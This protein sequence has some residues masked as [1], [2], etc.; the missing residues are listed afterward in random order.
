MYISLFIFFL[1][2]FL[3]VAKDWNVQPGSLKKQF[4]NHC[5]G[6][7]DLHTDHS[8][9]GYGVWIPLPQDTGN[10]RVTTVYLPHASKLSIPKGGMNNWVSLS[11]SLSVLDS[12]LSS[13]LVLVC[14][15]REVGTV[16]E[17]QSVFCIS[18]VVFLPLTSPPD[19][20]LNL[21]QCKKHANHPGG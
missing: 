11:L 16:G 4:E 9:S 6:T 21:Q 20:E 19:S 17:N 2:T 3:L 18:R 8:G 1:F 12:D 5:S 7:L 15:V 14:G 13:R 10:K